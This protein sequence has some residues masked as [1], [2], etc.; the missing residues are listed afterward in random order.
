MC[1]SIN[2]KIVPGSGSVGSIAKQE[3]KKASADYRDILGHDHKSAGFIFPCLIA[4]KK[5]GK[6]EKERQTVPFVLACDAINCC[7][8]VS[9]F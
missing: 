4:K 2:F 9:S 8:F 7:L 1:A 3:D 5:E 6:T